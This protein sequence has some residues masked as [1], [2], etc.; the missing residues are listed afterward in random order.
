MPGKFSVVA[1]ALLAVA[2]VPTNARTHEPRATTVAALENLA[3]RAQQAAETVDAFHA[4]LA[5]GDTAGALALLAEDALIFEEGGAERSRGAYAAEHLAA[6]AEYTA[7]V[8]SILTRRSGGATGG[9]A[10]IATEGRTTGRF[11][12]RAVDR[13]TTE[14]MVLERIGGHWRIVHIH[15]SSRA[16]SQ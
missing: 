9:V 3:P 4:A 14:T 7:A 10:W 13:I 6:D 2:I 12:D 11:R 5:R 16:S 1:L 15:W 8:P